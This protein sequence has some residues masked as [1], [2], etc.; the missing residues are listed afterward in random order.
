MNKPSRSEERFS[1]QK[2]KYTERCKDKGIEP[3]QDY[4]DMFEVMISDHHKKFDDEKSRKY[5]LEYDLL[6]TEWILEKTRASIIYSQN[7]YAALANN[8]FQKFTE[9]WEILK[10]STWGCS[11]RY[12]GGIIADM[13]QEGDYIDWYCSGI[14]NDSEYDQEQH[15]W[16]DE[17]L[18]QFEI[19]KQYVSE[20]V[21]TEEI[22]NDLHKLGWNPIDDQT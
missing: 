15:D 17:Q 18:A 13:R 19:Y 20:G 4:L 14:R 2:L 7:L 8:E 3:N 5:N 10:D 22:R 11:W 16:T 12:A 1:F 6:T 21:I 9:P